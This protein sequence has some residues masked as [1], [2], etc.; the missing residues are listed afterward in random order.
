MRRIP[1]FSTLLIGAVLPFSMLSLYAEEPAEWIFYGGKIVTVDKDFRIAEAMATRGDRIIGVGST[2]EILRLAGPNTQRVDLQ[3][4]MVLPGLID[5]HSHPPGASIYEFDHEVP[6]MESI[7]DVLAYI[8]QRTKVVPKGEWIVIQQVFVTRLKE[9]RFPTKDELDR[10]APEHPV[11]FRTGPDAALNS[12]ALKLSGIDRNFQITDGKPGFI[13]RDPA[14]G[15]PT[16]I[17]RSCTRLVKVTDS[18][19]SP[20]P[21]QRREALRRLLRAY[22]EVGLTSV[23]D[24]SAT[25]STIQLYSQLLERGELTCRVF[26]TYYVD[27]QEP[28]ERIEAAIKKAI[29]HPLH[30]YNPW[31]W[32][33][34]LK[35]F[36]DGGMLTGSAYMREPWG[37]S[38]IYGITDPNYRGVIF[39]DP[40]KLYQIVRTA[41]AHGLQ[42][43]A[44]AVGDGAV[45]ALAEAYARVAGEL[46]TRPLRPCI[47]HANFMSAEAIE[48]MAKHG[49]VADLQP[50]WL[51]HDGST[52]REHFGER[53]LRFFQ[54]YRTLAEK[55]VVVGG[56]SDHMQKVGR[57]RSIN[58]YDPWLGIWAV[59][60]RLPRG[61]GKPLHSEEAISREMAIRLYTINNA[62]LTFE[63]DKKGSLEPG[64]YADFI[65]VDRDLLTCPIG[66][67]ADTQVLETWVG[68]KR[69]FP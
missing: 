9:K 13:E 68:G 67:I 55:G 5:S 37:V 17:L 38:K 32:L 6:P 66:D 24:R 11:M 30:Q 41:L 10:A 31:L 49:I 12:V 69:V 25:D 39:L 16:G 60:T 51:Y 28:L 14:T 27:A 56:G 59:L 3:G 57:R 18:V 20:N 58:I 29:S 42:P 53:R 46:D 7:E 50:I 26:L 23:V 40:E 63:E 64:K 19:R 21:E 1:W 62:F 52:L 2:E 65:I 15:E 61:S 44:H 47:S 43:T 4:K 35:F 54:P 48:L 34:G 45:L 22:N 36:L 8:R 33:R